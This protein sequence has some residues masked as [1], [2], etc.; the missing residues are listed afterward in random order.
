[1]RPSCLQSRSIKPNQ[2]GSRP[3]KPNGQNKIIRPSAS[4]HAV[5]IPELN[6]NSFL[7]GEPTDQQIEMGRLTHHEYVAARGPFLQN[8][9]GRK[10]IKSLCLLGCCG[11]ATGKNKRCGSGPQ[12]DPM[13]TRVVAVLRVQ[14]GRNED[15]RPKSEEWSR[16]SCN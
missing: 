9:A 3:V 13:F 4:D 15:R 7:F 5:R 11:F 14:Q 10:I 1:M 2:T 8:V 6:K 16:A 12:K